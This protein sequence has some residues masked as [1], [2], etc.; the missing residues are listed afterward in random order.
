MIRDPRILPPG[1]IRIQVG[2]YPAA[3]YINPPGQKAL[4]A[5]QEERRREDDK[6]QEEIKRKFLAAISTMPPEMRERLKNAPEE[7]KARNKK[8]MSNGPCQVLN[9]PF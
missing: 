2:L 6:L 1:A 9:P 3:V 4:T 5:W 7:W 8:L